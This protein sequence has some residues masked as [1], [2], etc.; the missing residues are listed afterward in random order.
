MTLVK[1]ALSAAAAMEDPKAFTNQGVAYDKDGNPAQVYGDEA[2]TRDALGW[3]LKKAY[4]EVG[5]SGMALK[6]S[7]MIGEVIFQKTGQSI[8]TLNDDERGGRE[9]VIAALR[10]AAAVIKMRKMKLPKHQESRVAP[11]YT[12]GSVLVG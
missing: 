7:E 5:T 6:A 8:I 12:G 9:R 10:G 11:L 3:V 4:D 2:V 1:I